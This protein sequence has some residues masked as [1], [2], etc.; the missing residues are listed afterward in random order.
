MGKNVPRSRTRY[1]Y[2]LLACA[3]DSA[4]S[5]QHHSNGKL[6]SRTHGKGSG[7]QSPKPTSG[8]LRLTTHHLEDILEELSSSASEQQQLVWLICSR[9]TRAFFGRI[10]GQSLQ[11]QPFVLGWLTTGAPC[12]LLTVS[13]RQLQ[14][15]LHA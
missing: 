4:R 6:K 9:I 5:D 3:Q 10:P 15:W 14:G 8:G 7:T 13:T 2:G 12:A 1:T 11:R